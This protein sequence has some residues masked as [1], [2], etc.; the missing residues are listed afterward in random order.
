[1]GSIG[2]FGSFTTALLGMYTSQHGLSVT[3]NNISNI[4]T[5]GYTRQSLDQISLSMSGPD[6]YAQR[7]NVK[8]GNGALAVGVSQLRDP[9][10]DIRYR[11]E[12]AS[13]GA[14][15]KRLDILNSIAMVLDEIGAGD[16]ENGIISAQFS[17]LLKTL[18][19][20]S[21]QTNQGEYD[22]QVRSSASALA[23]LFNSA[24]TELEEV[25]N[26]TVTHFKQDL[27][28]VNE[29]LSNIRDLNVSIRKCDLHGDPGLE[30]R[31]ERN[32]L[33]DE[34]SEYV[35]IDV[36]YTEEDI[37]MGMTIEKL[38][39]RLANANPDATVSTDSSLLVD[40]VYATQIELPEKVA[41]LN[42]NY[43]PKD[44]ATGG[45]YMG[46]NGPVDDIAQANQVDNDN[47]LLS[48]T[49]LYD[50]AGREWYS[51]SKPTVTKLADKAAFDAAQAAVLADPNYNPVNQSIDDGKG[52]RTIYSFSEKQIT[53]TDGNVIGT[54]YYQSVTVEKYTLP[55]ALDD[56]DLYGS[57]QSSREM[58]T[59]S[60]EFASAG[61]INS[62]DERAS[63]KRGIRY[64]QR[65][66]DLLAN[67]VATLFNEANNGYMTDEDG[68]YVT[69]SG[70]A[71]ELPGGGKI[72]KYIP[73]TADQQAA[74]GKPLQEYL[75]ENGGYQPEGAGNLF[76]NHGSSDDADNIT[77]ANISIAYK[78]SNSD[79]KLIA[80]Y[81][82]PN[83]T[84]ETSSTANENILHFRALM[85]G[86]FDYIPSD[87]LENASD[88]PMFH[89]SF[90]GMMNN[91]EGILGNDQRSTQI[92]VNSYAVRA[93][94]VDTG[95]D[96]VSGVDLNDEAANLIR[97]Q[98]A[99]TAACRLMTTLDEALERLISNTGIV[100]R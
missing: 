74:L 33:I 17:D 24:A 94:E 4:N 92:Q 28:A 44:P 82:R 15:S 36:T 37:G 12:A 52:S 10:L 26:S 8:I 91:I 31:D 69:A 9:Y 73:L 70:D 46:P 100:G 22:T 88:I 64:Y 5:P 98:K 58:L 41:E 7:N 25:Y 23:T 85:E 1:M 48:L 45:P 51:Q 56:N 6:R 11:S 79:V 60:G 65:S 55:V 84:G 3:G 19:N 34:L 21:D 38:S 59:E 53:D 86:N 68:N 78:W 43:D 80:S 97:Y 61:Y 54:E 2:T 39:I 83:S 35:K 57:L 77:A 20:L 30:L 14:T 62:V 66:L 76:S 71:I 95:R 42:P 49:K 90:A 32:R 67:K 47:F 81:I 27:T 29:I 18:Q 93:V 87:I 40:G 89:G 99:Y 96:S 75:A 72:N 63:S 13:V 16:D 50:T